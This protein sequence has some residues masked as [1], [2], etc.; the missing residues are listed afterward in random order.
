MRRVDRQKLAHRTT[1]NKWILYKSSDV[2]VAA[3]MFKSFVS[4]FGNPFTS[5]S[6][7]P[8]D[9]STGG[10]LKASRNECGSVQRVVM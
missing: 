8:S 3:K 9:K 4:D 10:W 6:A 1:P 7:N 2:L 5:R